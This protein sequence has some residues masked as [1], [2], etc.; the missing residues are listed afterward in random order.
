MGAASAT[1]SSVMTPR[2]SCMQFASFPTVLLSLHQHY[3]SERILQREL[4]Q[5]RSAV[6]LRDL[7]NRSAVGNVRRSSSQWV[8]ERRMVEQIEELGA[9]MQSPPFAQLEIL[10]EREVD[11]HLLRANDAIAGRIAIPSSAGR[12][13]RNRRRRLVSIGVDPVCDLGGGAARL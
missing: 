11:V 7:A 9:E 2:F 5:P 4:N 13:I 10:A 6:G 8:L 12:G 3:S 1:P